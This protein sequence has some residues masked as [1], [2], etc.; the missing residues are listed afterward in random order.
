[1]ENNRKKATFA[2]GC[3]WCTEAVFQRFE[4]I[5]QVKSGYTGGFVKNPPYREVAMGRTNHAEAIQFEYDPDVISYKELLEVFFT[6]H[7][8]TTLN[9][10]GN[11]VGTQYRS[12]I[13]YSDES[14]KEEAQTYIE[15]LNDEHVFDNPIVT[16]VTQLDAFYP[17]EIE[18]DDYYNRNKR[19]G[20]CQFIINPKIDKIKK[21]YQVKLK[22]EYA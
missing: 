16:E 7:D 5:Y 14:Q 20:Y 8:P 11:D 18:H 10:Q 21:H 12:A 3:F 6:T 15:R 9:R 19:Q 22:K 13:F 4:G 17:A 1:M 2:N